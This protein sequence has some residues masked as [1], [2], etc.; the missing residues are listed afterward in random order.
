MRKSLA[1][2][3]LI[4]V[5]ILGLTGC[6]SE[7]PTP[8][9]EQTGPPITTEVELTV[10]GSSENVLFVDGLWFTAAAGKTNKFVATEEVTQIS[11][12]YTIESLPGTKT[13]DVTSVYNTVAILPEGQ[14]YT[15]TISV[16]GKV[17]AE[18]TGEANTEPDE[19]SGE[20][21]AAQE[22]QGCSFKGE[23]ELKG[24]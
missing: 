20:I 3:A 10:T 14:T 17:V 15:C 9:P 13:L 18:V 8:A 7:E 4:S 2:L 22:D 12:K 6:T 11:E 1:A 24:Q 21:L 5:S 16:D 23:I 19:V